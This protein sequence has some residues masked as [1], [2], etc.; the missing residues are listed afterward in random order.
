MRKALI[1][2]GMVIVLGLVAALVAA[3]SGPDLAPKQDSGLNAPGHTLAPVPPGP[4]SESPNTGDADPDRHHYGNFTVGVEDYPPA[5]VTE[6]PD[7]SFAC[8]FGGSFLTA[9]VTTLP[10][11]DLVRWV[12]HSEPLTTIDFVD[13]VGYVAGVILGGRDVV[14]IQPEMWSYDTITLTVT[15]AASENYGQSVTVCATSTDPE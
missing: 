1:T 12:V 7:G 14:A 13:G 2:I 11:G 9:R 4:P 6:Q 10:N 3:C 15:K 5:W 8:S